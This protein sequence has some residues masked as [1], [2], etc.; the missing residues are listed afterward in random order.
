[1]A[2]LKY[3]QQF[4]RLRSMEWKIIAT[5]RRPTSRGCRRFAF[6]N[7]AGNIRGLPRLYVRASINPF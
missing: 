3:G 1:V 4:T 6:P 7:I 5:R 2:G